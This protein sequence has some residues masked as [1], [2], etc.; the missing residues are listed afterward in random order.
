MKINDDE[1][2]KFYLRHRDRLEEW[3]ALRSEAAAAIDE[4][5]TSLQG[6]IEEMATE[7]AGDVEP[8]IAL[9]EEPA[10]PGL[11]LKRR[12]WPGTDLQAPALIGLQWSRGKTLLTRESTPSVGVRSEKS[13]A[14]HRGLKANDEFQRRRR[15][16]KDKASPWWPAYGRVI[17]EGRFPEEADNYRRQVIGSI[18]Q[19]WEA[20]AS[21]I[22]DVIEKSALTGEPSAWPATK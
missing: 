8:L 10:W 5:L 22:D 9:T 14:V 4:W 6:D 20:Y 12:N 3:F 19:A 15:Q 16:R 21:L 7:V 2:V 18:R 1:R 11:Y 13:T 17:P